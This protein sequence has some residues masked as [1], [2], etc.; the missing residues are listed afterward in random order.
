MTT[1][2]SPSIAA[3]LPRTLEEFLAWEPN[4]GVKY[5]WNDG[6]L[7]ETENMNRKLLFLIGRLYQL[8]HQTKAFQS[9]GLLLAEQDVQLSGIQLR[10]PDLAYFNANQIQQNPEN[11]EPIPEFV[12]EIISSNDQIYQVEK[13]IIEYFK[14]GVKVVW[15]ILSEEKVVYVYTSRQNVKICIENDICSA[16]PVLPD[17]EV[18]VNALLDL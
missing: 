3:E 4:D 5:E 15:N 11:D 14:A 6:E 8:F 1:Q 18:S 2:T 16:A 7:I 10:R 12:I 13:K 9:G 17:F